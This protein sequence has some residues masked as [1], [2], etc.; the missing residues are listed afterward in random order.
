MW[1]VIAA[2]VAAFAIPTVAGIYILSAFVALIEVL[3]LFFLPAILY[4]DSFRGDRRVALVQAD[5]EGLHFGKSLVLPRKR[6]DACAIEPL[7]EGMC[8]VQLWGA[9]RRDDIGL[10]VPEERARLLL[11]ALGLK[12]D[13]HAARFLVES[14]PLRT[15]GIARLMRLATLFGAALLVAAVILFTLQSEW[16]GFTLVP[17]MFAYFGIVRRLRRRR[18]IT[19]GADALTVKHAI[20]LSELRSVTAGAGNDALVKVGG[21]SE[22]NSE[23]GGSELTLRFDG[24]HPREKRDAF[25]ER[26]QKSLDERTEVPVAAMLDPGARDLQAWLGELRRLGGDTYRGG[27]LPTEELWRVVEHASAPPGARVGALAMLVSRLDDEGRVRLSVLAEGTVKPE[28][29]AA[30]EAAADPGTTDEDILRVREMTF[31][32]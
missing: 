26:L 15:A 16:V 14:S 31:D 19:L 10:L 24:R 7:P 5:A 6:I 9:G 18:T 27:G 8:N 1:P 30:L 3:L 21:K 32:K 13:R 28:V 22:G 2:A 23:V 4:D 20:P 25:V 17:L 12:N 29:R 11:D